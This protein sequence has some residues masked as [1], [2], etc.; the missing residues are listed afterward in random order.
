MSRLKMVAFSKTSGVSP[1]TILRA[2]PSAMAVLPT[3][4]SPTR[5]GLFLRRR[6]STWMQRSTS[7]SRPIKGSTSPLRALALRSTQ[8]FP[9]ADSLPSSSESSSEEGDEVAAAAPVTGRD[10]PKD[11][12]LATPWAMKLT[13]S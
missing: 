6:H 13:A 12:S 7:C 1:C 4:G 10:S 3:P 8:Y 2:S 11:G 9:K 5:S